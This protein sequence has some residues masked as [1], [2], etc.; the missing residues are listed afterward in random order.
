MSL[1]CAGEALEY[2]EQARQSYEQVARE[3]LSEETDVAL[4]EKQFSFDH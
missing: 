3:A 1:C 2:V 4:H